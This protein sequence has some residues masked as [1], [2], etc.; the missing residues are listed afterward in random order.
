[1]QEVEGVI[2]DCELEGK[3]CLIPPLCAEGARIMELYNT[4][5]SLHE[6]VDAGTILALYE[7]Q[8]EDLEILATIKSEFD[9]AQ[10]PQT[11]NE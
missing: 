6:L 2:P 7:A 10:R 11:R 3:A 9:K 1:M 5:R 8:R 4:L